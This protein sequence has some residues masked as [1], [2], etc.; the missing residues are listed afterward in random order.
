MRKAPP[1]YAVLM[2]GRRLKL[3]KLIVGANGNKWQN[4][5]HFRTVVERRIWLVKQ[6]GNGGLENW[7]TRKMHTITLI[8][9]TVLPNIFSLQTPK[10]TIES[11]TGYDVTDRE[12]GLAILHLHRL[13]HP[14]SAQKKYVGLR[15]IL[16][17]MP[18]DI[19]LIAMLPVEP[20]HCA[21]ASASYGMHLSHLLPTFPLPYHQK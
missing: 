17:R 10:G 16:P 20:A 11:G 21:T 7:R 18:S 4:L 14:S 1:T 19:L 9:I 3:S 6:P 2:L 13:Y 8:G 12:N 15:F 5:T